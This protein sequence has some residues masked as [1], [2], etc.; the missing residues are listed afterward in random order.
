MEGLPG[1]DGSKPPFAL[2][3]HFHFASAEALGT[4]MA[5]PRRGELQADIA[6]FTDITPVVVIGRAL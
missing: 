3:G 4:A 6:N 2:I 5:N 1:P